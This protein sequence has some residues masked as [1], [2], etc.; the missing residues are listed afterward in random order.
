MGSESARDVLVGRS[1][2]EFVLRQRIGQ[3]GFGAVYRASQPAL[4]REAVIKVL[5]PELHA[6]AS[7]TERFLREAKLASKLDHP[8]AAH[9]YAFGAES[10]GELWIAMELV[11]GTPLDQVLKIQGPIPLERFLPLL[12]RICEVVHTAHEQGIVHRDL[13]P[14]NVMVLARAGRLLPK[15]LDFGIAKGSFV[16][17]TWSET[18]LGRDSTVRVVGSIPIDDGPTIETGKQPGAVGASIELTQ[19]GV[20]M[21]SPPYMAPEQWLDAGRVDARTDL[22]ALGVLAYECVVGKSPFGGTTLGQIAEAHARQMPPPV[23]AHLPSALDGVFARALAKQASERFPDAL[24]FAAAFRHASGIA[25]E[26]TQF[27]VLDTARRDAMLAGAPQPIAE[28]ISALE[29]ARNAYQARDALVQL[30]HTITR[31]LG[32]IALSCHSRI[33]L[34]EESAAVGDGMREACRRSL[35]DREWLELTRHL[36]AE[37]RARRDAYPVPELVE[38]CHEHGV[39]D[40]LAALIALRERELASEDVLVATLG[41]EIA[42]LGHL[43]DALE[44]IND[45]GLVVTLPG[46]GAERWMGVRRMPRTIVPVRGKDLPRGVAALV[47]AEAVPVLSLAPLLQVA[48]PAPGSPPELFLFD[49]RDSRGAKLVALPG[50]FERHDEEVLAWFRAQLS[51]SLDEASSA[52]VEE[53]SPYRGLTAFSANDSTSFFGR[54]KLVDASVNRLKLLPLLAIVGRSGAGKSSFVHAGMVPALAWRAITIRPGSSPLGALVARLEHQGVRDHAATVVPR[55]PATEPPALADLRLTL[56]RDRNALG[57]LLRADAAARGPI[58]VVVDQLEEMFT[59]CHDADERR[60]FAEAL[61]AAARDLDDPVRVVVTLRDDFL[62]RSEQVPGLRNRIAQGLQLLTVPAADDLLRILVEPARRAGY[63]FDDPA[64]PAEMV[65]EVAD[66]PGALA[67]ISFTA[68]KLWELRDRHFKQLTRA[69]YRT[70]GGV[71]GALARHADVTLEEMPL[72]ERAL[73]RGAFRHLV[74]SQNTRAV[75][76]RADLRQLLGDGAPADRVIEKLVVAR[77]L[78]AAEN[79]AGAETIE[80]VHEALLSTWPRLVDWRREDVEGARFREQLRA[81]AEQWHERGRAKGLL[82]SGDAFTDLTR[83]RTRHRGPLTEL[84]AAFADASEAEAAR[85]RRNR[86]VLLAAVFG[87]LLIVV[88]GLLVF[89]SSLDRQRSSA[90]ASARELHDNLGHQYDEQGRRLVLEGDPLLA[91]AYLAKATEYGV[92]GRAHDFLV[93]EAVRATD[94]ERFQ[95][96][97]DGSVVTA[98]FSHD[99]R[100][101]VTASH[102]RTARIW[103]AADG[104]PLVTLALDGPALAAEFLPGDRSVLAATTTGTVTLWNAS[105]GASIA[106]FVHPG[107][108]RCA[109]MSSDG[110]RAVTGGGTALVIWQL[111]SGTELA[112]ASASDIQ[113]CAFSQDGALVAGG[114]LTGVTRLWSAASGELRHELRG[115]RDQVLRLAF[116]PDGARLASTSSDTTA[117]EWDVAT[118]RVLHVFQHNQPVGPVAWSPDQRWLVIGANGGDAAIWDAETGE[119]KTAL[120][121]Q[122]SDLEAV[123]FSPDGS[124]VVTGSDDTTAILSDARTGRAL[125]RWRDHRNVLQ[126]VSFDPSGHSVVTASADG[127]ASVLAA[128]AQESRTPLPA[129]VGGVWWVEF[130]SDGRR[131]I[132]SGLDGVAIVSDVATGRPE[133]RLEA[134]NSTMV[135]ARFSPDDHWIATA[136]WDGTVR[137][138]DARSGAAGSVLAHEPARIQHIAWSPTGG[139][140]VAVGEDGSLRGWN[141]ATGEPTLDRRGPPLHWVAFDPTGRTLA[142]VTDEGEGVALSDAHGESQGL[143]R[144]PDPVRL[145]EFDHSGR[146]LLVLTQRA[147]SVLDATTGA[148]VA[149]L[150]GHVGV[151]SHASL[152]PDGELVATA[153][154]DGTARIWSARDG[155][156][157]AIW[158]RRTQVWAVAFAPDG[159]RVA[160]GFADGTSEIVDLPIDSRSSAEIARLVACRVPYR[161]EGDRI[162]PAA[163]DPQRCDMGSAREP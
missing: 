113:T 68:A 129:H 63:E 66:Q 18:D 157:L 109:A 1:L 96:R 159:S 31:Y 73:V 119:R 65:E 117:I 153:S 26:S 70:L 67:L 101:L 28:A 116:S 147:A 55:R 88:I 47:D 22:Y 103:D 140:V 45:Y 85:G 122:D 72:E 77:L 118:G 149:E 61:A 106:R 95:V 98:R 91:L 52:V 59:L 21:G 79:D 93:A 51:S 107:P 5:R 29:G 58:L 141:I 30:A 13:K 16:P 86:R 27:P 32:L 49:G 7:A 139:T 75:V 41:Q 43:L 83:W 163:S 69:A 15:L 82:W 57:A 14:A 160:L 112:R 12:D 74:T 8:Y 25:A 108:V 11:R 120:A 17:Q 33:S 2:G 6:S 111:P 34:G 127:T 135:S 10:D 84:E 105:N 99:G 138:W 154:E 87:L 78:V 81:A 150:I 24:A 156:A 36:T 124:L 23:P 133:L 40:D 130:S 42:R 146:H 137:L 121:S 62:I 44:F 3:G 37:W 110:T 148:T 143:L 64:L 131:V 35:T 80:I 90:Q 162:E 132:T 123:A 102:D 104:R 92:S 125:A 100:R 46:G 54:E 56:E 151:I 155:R 60:I 136:G 97:H 76:A 114:D 158:R 38:A 71:G 142:T 161:I 128:T 48:A 115:H 89:S 4:D 9:V 39:L 126:D 53:R 134:H 50:G 19:R 144:S 20:I 94:G 145:A 152:S